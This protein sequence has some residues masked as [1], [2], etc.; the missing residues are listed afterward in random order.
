MSKIKNLEP[1]RFS[2]EGVN[3]LTP[4]T[5]QPE[6]NY[7]DKGLI[8]ST[9]KCDTC[10]KEQLVLIDPEVRKPY[11]DIKCYNR[12]CSNYGYSK[13]YDT[14]SKANKSIEDRLIANKFGVYGELITV[15]YLDKN[16]LLCIDSV[17]FEILIVNKEVA[18]VLDN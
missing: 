14:I 11:G 2:L 16:T 17:T 8:F 5:E 7:S 13:D 6:E 1:V 4:V 3:G 12:D 18:K 10:G 15:G 9:Y